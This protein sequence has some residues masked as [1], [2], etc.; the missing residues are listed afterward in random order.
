VRRQ[1]ALWIVIVAALLAFAAGDAQAESA[2]TI[3]CVHNGRLTRYYTVA[4]LQ[5]ALNTMPADI[6][7]YNSECYQ[8]ISNQL[9]QQLN[10]ATVTTTTPASSSGSS[11]ISAPLL[12]VLAV[13]LLA[14]GGFVVAARRR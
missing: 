10:D 9:N 1:C 2:A 12:I 7:E 4:E 14:G 11:L 8:L 5:T 6:K 13:V 3:D